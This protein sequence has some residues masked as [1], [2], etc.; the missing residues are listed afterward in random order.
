MSYFIASRQNIASS[1]NF[2]HL[3]LFL[4]FTMAGIKDRLTRLSFVLLGSHS[5]YGRFLCCCQGGLNPKG[6][7]KKKWNFPLRGGV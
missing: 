7:V 3:N 6:R 4:Q 5:D 1:F 2:H